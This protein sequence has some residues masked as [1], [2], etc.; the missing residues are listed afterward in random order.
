MKRRIAGVLMA[1][2]MLLSLLPVQALAE[3]AVVEEPV[4]E[5]EQVE[6]PGEVGEP[7]VPDDP[8]VPEEPE[9]E[10][11]QEPV[12]EVEQTVVQGEGTLT[13][14]AEPMGTA[15]E[16]TEPGDFD[17]KLSV[18][19]SIKLQ[20]DVDY[21]G[22]MSV[23]VDLT[24]D[25]NGYVLNM[26]GI[27][28][29]N[30]GSLTIID[31]RSD[32]EHKFTPNADGLWV[33]DEQNGTKTV[34]GGVIYGG[35]GSR[36]GTSVYGGGVY[37]EGGGTF[38]M[39]GG[40]IVGC[41]A[42]TTF[43]ARGGGVFV[44]DRGTFT[45]SGGSITGC[46]TVGGYSY[47]GGI[48]NE[49]TMTLS[50]TAEIRDCHAKD[51]DDGE[52]AHGGGISSNGGTS[53]ISGNVRITGCTAS[54]GKT[55]AVSM[56]A[57]SAISGG[58][59]DGSV[60]NEGTIS[61]GTFNGRVVNGGTISDGTFNGEVVND[62]GTISGGTISGGTFNGVVTNYSTITEGVISGVTVTYQVKGTDYATQIVPSG[63]TAI[64]PV[65]PPNSVGADFLGWYRAD[66]TA[67]DFTQT[68]TENITLT[69]KFAAVTKIV[70]NQSELAAA[71]ANTNVDI[72][73]LYGNITIDTTLTVSREVTL[74]LNGSVLEMTRRRSVFKV[75]DGGHLTLED[76]APQAMHKF[77][78]YAKG[79]WRWDTS[80]TEI[81]KGGVIY[82]GY[83]DE[84]GGVLI[85]AGGRFTMN[86]GSIVGC[87]ADYSGGG[88]H[89]A[90]GGAFEMN[91]NAA[92]IGCVAN[93][94][95]GVETDYDSSTIYGKFIM[96]GGVIDSCVATEREGGGV[97]AS[98]P[99][100]M[101]GGEI[102][103]CVA[104]NGEGGGVFLGN[105]GSPH[106]LN[107]TINAGT[108]TDQKYVHLNNSDAVIG[109][110][111]NIHA[112][113]TLGGGMIALADGV[114]SAT[115]YGKI[116]NDNYGGASC[117]AD[118]L[119]AV[120]YQV[121]GED[122]ATQIV[123][124]G[125]T[126]TKPTA[127]AVTG[128]YEFDGWFKADGT[129]WDYT[130]AVTEN[131]TLMGW[132][133][134]PVISENTLLAALSGSAEVIRLTEDINISSSLTILR[135]VTLDLNGHVL[136]MTG[137]GSVIILHADKNSTTTG[138]LTLMDSDPTAEHKFKV[139]GVEPW[140]LDDSG[141]ETVR[142]GVIIGGTGTRIFSTIPSTSTDGG[143]VIIGDGALTMNGGNIVGCK[144][145][146]GGGLYIH[147]SGTF[148]MNGGSI[149]G[150]S[151][152]SKYSGVFIFGPMTRGSAGAVI[153]LTG[154]LIK[155][156]D[157][158][159]I[160][161]YNSATI[162]A[163]GG[164]VYGQVDVGVASKITS[165]AGHTGVT[166]FRGLTMI[167]GARESV[168]HIDWGIYYGGLSF[169][170]DGKDI[171][172][173]L[174]VTYKT[175]DTTEYAKQVLP[176]GT[177]ATQPDDPTKAGYDFAQWLKADGTAWDYASDT[178]TEDVTLTAQW[179]IRTTEV[180][181][182][183]ELKNALKDADVGQIRLT[184]DITVDAILNV[185]HGRDVILDLNG[186]VLDLG[187]KKIYVNDKSLATRLTIIDSRPGAE[188][189]FT[190]KADGLWVRDETNGTKTVKG[191][192]ITGGHSDASDYCGGID[193]GRNGTVIMEAGHIVGG[194]A[195]S[196]GGGV[197]LASGGIFTMNGGGITGCVAK[198]MGGG[199]YVERGT[200]TMNGGSITDCTARDGG[201]LYLCGTMNAG[202]G[203]VDG[204]VVLDRDSSKNGI[205]RDNNTGSTLF[206][207]NV[208][209]AGEIA[210]GIFN[211]TVTV[212]DGNASLGAING[213]T[214]NGPVNMTDGTD[215]SIIE[216]GIFNDTVTIDRGQITNGT[217]NKD[218]VVKKT[219]GITTLPVLADGTY[220]GLIKNGHE[221]AAF[222]GAYSEL[223]IVGKEPDSQSGNYSY[224]KVTF[225]LAGG[226]MDY[227]KRYF[228]DETHISDQ[229]KPNDR[230]GYFFEGWYNGT[231]LWDHA[232]DTVTGE[233]TLT[234]KWKECDH[235][236]HTG[237]QPT[238][239]TSVI[240]TE[241][242][243]TMPALGHDWGA[244]T[245]NGDNTHTHVCK[246]DASHTETKSCVDTDRDHICND[247]GKTISNHEDV[248]KNHVCDYCGKT[249]SN[250]E[251]VD[252]N[253]VC[254]YCGKTISN[255]ED[256]DKNHVCDY[257]G[258][259][260]SNHTGGTAYCN[261]AKVCGYC[262]KSYG[263]KDPANHANLVNVP[264]KAATTS[265]EGNIEYW[266]CDGCNKYY[267]DAA[268][269]DEITQE[270]T[271]IAKRRVY[272]GPTIYP[273]RNGTNPSSGTEYP[274]GIYGLIYR[275]TVSKITGVQVDGRTI[276][277]AN[278]TTEG[279][280]P[281]ELYLKASYLN[282][283]A[284]GSHTLTVLTDSGSLTAAFTVGDARTSP[285]T[286]DAGITVYAA[287]AVTSLTGL[288]LLRRK[289]REEE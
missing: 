4:T 9:Q 106:T 205:I 76:S 105:S 11:E 84:G 32:A 270:D 75:A 207:G 131:T 150:C 241:C 60:Q 35:T 267:K 169:V 49:G 80:G 263:D 266:Y 210:H 17:I 129:A 89:V 273:V 287:A 185:K 234:A 214:F 108:A 215:G 12:Q 112:N 168:S 180:K 56:D 103:N 262:G 202:G 65:D 28:V 86:G 2:V 134:V 53:K 171:T 22:P 186:Y 57:G 3:D 47:G 149:V 191:G 282:R 27:K 159:D 248:D 251:D 217:F 136:K 88:V 43:Q 280:Y 45:M 26:T 31:S 107:G 258:K 170:D 160:R 259:T 201:A 70:A 128:S 90:G 239:T 10:V 284:R 100:V 18:G 121:N 161:A 151:A 92:I 72:V 140:T 182:A 176:A 192:V 139:N 120:T 152:G 81:V 33:L 218:V 229:I 48:Y 162:Y 276:G 117:Y 15:E 190:P 184:D 206:N 96:N 111:A 174:I 245:S 187:G 63:S 19:G 271:V 283:L 125:S 172:T 135:K 155:N 208:T 61:G 52:A 148:T 110:N 6:E 286:F 46:T 249:I 115:V 278:Y 146:Y 16:T 154:G 165:L 213:G 50:G 141:T 252:K 133:Y 113:I 288:E 178:V 232:K 177:L 132:L 39:N 264:A 69:A 130:A 145:Y 209:N 198:S 188:H 55:D 143:G 197:H 236:G 221:E 98:A 30:G 260:I 285:T 199:V 225:D 189:K 257:C 235:S 77:N 109:A 250:H 144:A 233:M 5:I 24:I 243:G 272:S 281:V 42:S 94:G 41:T 219:E 253:H 212:G 269:Q 228:R 104:T 242:G 82:G 244:W 227:T 231:E 37:V 126:A 23:L 38:T 254:D 237:V 277:K 163:N 279:S 265:A 156:N 230:A 158:C 20:N 193:I 224:Y 8:E 116:T 1:L 13:A 204:T 118:G 21:G 220:N 95:G 274:G 289:R 93:S 222:I 97:Y 101:E 164:E 223:G 14:S 183:Q 58:T 216:G 138:D 67:Y 157:K 114:S 124:S 147:Y 36:I 51:R 91:N 79:L 54:G 142:G 153:T 195:D 196:Y 122:Y 127:P 166:T 167:N 85:E 40:N 119:V 73:Q 268:A 261:A 74:D 25:L 87:S 137:S 226:K 44:A 200:F 194:Y 71:L 102:K 59:F 181:T 62:G 247:C 255:H 64:K 34:K 240:C 66:G 68:V 123:P 256:A 275:A 173:G 99:F 83:A 78:P 175:D 246:R 211:G 179:A 29:E 203:T 238:C 7:E